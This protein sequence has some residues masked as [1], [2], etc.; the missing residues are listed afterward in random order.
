[1]LALGVVV[2]LIGGLVRPATLAAQG[3]P[4]TVSRFVAAVNA[5]DVAAI[6]AFFA[7]DAVYHNM[8]NQPIRGVAAIRRAI[9]NFVNPA[10]TI[11]WE[12]TRMAATGNTVL[13][14]R[15]DRFVIN[16]K[17]VALPVMGSFD[18]A[19]GKITA[20]RDYFD[21]ATWQRQT[22]R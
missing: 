21:V 2:A 9:E 8:P 15:I 17:D 11:N 6:M 10:S 22:A 16:G 19:N 3:G 12:I 4:E 1:V 7:E 5:K 18:L 14:E 20:W 13:T